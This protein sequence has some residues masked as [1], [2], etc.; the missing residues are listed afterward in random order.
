[1]YRGRS[2]VFA[3][4]LLVGFCA[5]L[6]APAGASAS[7]SP[8]SWKATPL[9]GT[10]DAVT[11]QVSCTSPT[12]CMTVTNGQTSPNKSGV[13]AYRWDGRKW[14]ATTNPTSS[15]YP[16]TMV[17]C[18]SPTM[19]VALA[20]QGY[21][22][23]WDGKGWGTEQR[24]DPDQQASEDGLSCASSHF[25]V[26]V[27]DDQ[28]TAM[29]YNGSSWKVVGPVDP[30]IAAA[31]KKV[32][33]GNTD[34]VLDLTVS[35]GIGSN[36]CVVA[37][38][39]G[40]TEV[41]KAAPSGSGASWTGVAKKIK[42]ISAQNGDGQLSLSCL[43]A[44]WCVLA[45]YQEDRDFAY[46]TFNGA[47]WTGPG[48]VV[49]PMEGDSFS[50]SVISCATEHFCGGLNTEGGWTVYNGSAWTTPNN[51]LSQAGALS[52]P[53]ANFCMETGDYGDAA[54]WSP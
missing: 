22:T 3:F 13:W 10:N 45:S 41:V 33:A 43:S 48:T 28:G 23:V 25:C 1:M 47:A 40:N 34:A 50:P 39:A 29:A 4:A 36:T 42:D 17:S 37:D 8:G 30:A 9:L 38:D 44:K 31:T 26:A 49:I 15:L 16:T 51:E 53:T 18:V 12:F 5:V 35:C 24:V 46:W 21:A 7:R 54:T 2:L 14:V 20:I 52:C 27:D 19:C 6:A 11:Y 32:N